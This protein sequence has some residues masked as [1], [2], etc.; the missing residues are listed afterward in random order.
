MA[1]YEATDGP[2]WTGNTNWL[3]DAP[4][5]QWH[6]VTVDADGRVTR[7][8]LPIKVG[9][10]SRLDYLRLYGNNLTGP[11]PPELGNLSSLK[12]M[13]LSQTGICAPSDPAVLSWLK[14]IYKQRV[15]LCDVGDE[16]TAYL[17]PS[18]QSREHPVP[19]VAD[20]PA[21]LRVFPRAKIANSEGQGPGRASR[22]GRSR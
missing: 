5:G 7:L 18:T 8:D 21:L 19:L 11:I 16:S 2:N 14:E 3:T 22:R 17:V 10:L 15:P 1:L 12:S 13:D 4:L 20:E 9:K 6:G